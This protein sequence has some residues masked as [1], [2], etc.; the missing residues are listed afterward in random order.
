MRQ[1]GQCLV[2]L[3]PIFCIADDKHMPFPYSEIFA[4]VSLEYV[5]LFAN[6]A[7]D[8]AAFISFFSI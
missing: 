1:T 6:F 7:A 2:R 3:L 8:S 4:K 5:T